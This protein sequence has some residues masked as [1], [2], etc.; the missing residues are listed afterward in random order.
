MPDQT[1]RAL[2][3]SLALLRRLQRSPADRATLADAVRIEV[4]PAAYGELRSKAEIKLFANDIQR[5]RELGVDIYY[6]TGAYHLVSYGEFSPVGLGE[7]GLNAL[8][9]LSESFG[10]GAPNS[11]AIQEL[12]SQVTDWLPAG[13]RDSLPA[14]RQRLRLDLRRRDRDQILPAVQEAIDRAVN[15]RRLLQFHYRAPGQADSTPRRH[16]VQPWGVYFDTLRRHLYLDAYCLSVSGPHGFFRQELWRTYRLGRILPDGLTVL[17]DRLPPEPPPRPR[18]PLEYWLAPEI[19]RQDEITAH[20]DHTQIHERDAQGWL[21]ITA[22][23]H[24]LFQATRLLLTYGPYCRVT[25][26]TAARQEML[27][28]VRGMAEW[29]GVSSA[30]QQK[31]E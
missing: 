19:A 18:I 28:L 29:Y 7:D 22:T 30:H 25:G 16:T 11:L 14:R 27:R 1:S 13:Q 21:R 8:A 31:D 10:P 5:L 6:H 2:L 15:Q 26:G 9:F 20:F 24:D 4:D 12:V 23:T 3:R 17:P